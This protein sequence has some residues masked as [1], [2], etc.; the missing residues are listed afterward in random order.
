MTGYST[1]NGPAA[2]H[3]DNC[4]CP[5]C[6][7]VAINAEDSASITGT[8]YHGIPLRNESEMQKAATLA[9]QIVIDM[10]K[11]HDQI[12]DVLDWKWMRGDLAL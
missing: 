2:L 12:D 5:A 10:T 3:P 4:H 7:D 8:T 9:E 11:W 1:P 6:V